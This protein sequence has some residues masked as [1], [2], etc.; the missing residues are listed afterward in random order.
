M[1]TRRQL[2]DRIEHNLMGFVLDQEEQTHLT[3]PLTADG[4]T[5]T[6]N[7]SHNVSHGTVQVG[8]ELMWVQ[9]IDRA[10]ATVT[11]A[12]YGRGFQSTHPVAH[13]VGERVTDNPKFPRCRIRET[14]AQAIEDLYPDLYRIGTTTFPYVAARLTYELPA[15]AKEVLSVN[16]DIIGPSKTWPTQK[17]WR[18]NPR[19]NTN[20]FPSGKTI[21]LWQPVIPGRTVQV[22]YLYEPGAF[23]ADDEEFTEATGLGSYAEEA[24]IYGACYRLV[25]WLETPRLQLEAV[26]STARSTLVPPEAA[27]EAGRYFYAL[28][29]ESLARARRRLLMEHPTSGHFRFI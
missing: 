20:T 28:Y 8:D 24:A 10:T 16:W 22:D 26:E 27:T 19:A 17:R 3:S 23:T 5:F 2:V 6:V 4:L 13:S 25:G 9:S 15:E 18:F 29:Q 7:E 12:P 11:V 21:D 14:L 1:S